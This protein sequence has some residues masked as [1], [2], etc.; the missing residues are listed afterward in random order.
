M[1]SNTL[2]NFSHLE[3]VLHEYINT[4]SSLYRDRL[5]KDGHVATEDLIN[6]IKAV[7][8]QGNRE[9]EVGLNLKDYWK[10]VEYDTKP[11]FPP[12]GETIEDP[13][14]LRW[15]HVKHLTDNAR[16]YDGK[17]PTEK[18]LAYLIA[19]KISRE[20]TT[21]THDLEQT[22]Q[23]LNAQFEVKIADAIG[24]DLNS[25]MISILSALQTE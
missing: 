10:Y 6:N 23:Q 1:A 2:I 22:I 16:T 12:I 9:I 11:H 25:A 24:E 13:G 5:I 8:H 3:Q 19:R 21:G 4:L 18:Q 17:L 20:G 7:F 15:V 14:I